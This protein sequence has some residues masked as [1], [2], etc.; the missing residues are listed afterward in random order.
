MKIFIRVMKAMSDPNRVRTIKLLQVKELCVCE[1]QPLLGLAQSTVSKHLKILEDSEFVQ[2]RRDGSWMIYQINRE[3]S[4]PYVLEL[5]NNLQHWHND[6]QIFLQMKEKLN[7]VDRL[8]TTVD[9]V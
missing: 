6:D 1:L 7:H 9:C 8:R 4:C 5:L 2:S 3:T